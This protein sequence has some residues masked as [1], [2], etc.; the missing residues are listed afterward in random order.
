MT[1]FPSSSLITCGNTNADIPRRTEGLRGTTDRSCRW[2]NDYSPGP[3]CAGQPSGE[4]RTSC[5]RR[6]PGW[7]LP[8][9]IQVQLRQARARRQTLPAGREGSAGEYG[10]RP[11]R[12]AAQ[13]GR[14]PQ[15]AGSC[16]HGAP[17][18]KRRQGAAGRPAGVTTSQRPP[19][20][21]ML[22]HFTSFLASWA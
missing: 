10:A 2:P 3:G 11:F 8:Y 13:P 19:N 22:W 14:L 20:P 12:E 18:R 15:T 4:E 21:W 6:S 1:T 7:V 9:G 16:L 5:A 17:H